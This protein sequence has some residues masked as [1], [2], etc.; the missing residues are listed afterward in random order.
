MMHGFI[1]SVLIKDKRKLSFDIL[2]LVDTSGLL[3]C[4]IPKNIEFSNV[5]YEKVY[6]QSI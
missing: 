2:T 4:V 3:N 6:Y 5:K 1:A